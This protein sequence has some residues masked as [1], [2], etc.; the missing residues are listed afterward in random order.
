MK[1]FRSS[2]NQEDNSEEEL[3]R[4]KENLDRDLFKSKIGSTVG[5]ISA[6][7]GPALLLSSAGLGLF[8][9]GVGIAASTGS[10]IYQ[11]LSVD[12]AKT[13]VCQITGKKIEKIDTTSDYLLKTTNNASKFCVLS[14]K[15][16]DLQNM[17]KVS[18]GYKVAYNGVN[19]AANAMK[20]AAK[21]GPVTKC[22]NIFGNVASCI[23]IHQ[24]WTTKNE[25]SE[26][27]KSLISN[28]K[29]ENDKNIK[30]NEKRKKVVKGILVLII[31]LFLCA[32]YYGF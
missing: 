30:N 10:S 28:K 3:I 11:K 31:F 21:L 6:I 18:S 24:T 13:K 12:R 25:T 8:L 9:T 5:N 14:T 16:R 32:L 17:T 20:T 26:Q 2:Q 4:T 19:G 1:F 27:L 23:D 29:S 7:A 15:A 22:L